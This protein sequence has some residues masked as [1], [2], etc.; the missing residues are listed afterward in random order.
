MELSRGAR[1]GASDLA[2]RSLE[3]ANQSFSSLPDEAVEVILFQLLTMETALG[4]KVLVGQGATDRARLELWP[5]Q[6]VSKQWR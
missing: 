2:A 4:P 1:R 3:F 5:L 6:L